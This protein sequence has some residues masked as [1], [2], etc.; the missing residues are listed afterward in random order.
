MNDVKSQTDKSSRL[1]TLTVENNA[2]IASMDVTVTA[3]ERKLYEIGFFDPMVNQD[4]EPIQQ[5]EQFY[6]S[7]VE[8]SINRL[9]VLRNRLDDI[10]KY[11]HELI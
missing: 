11:L 9:V 5:E 7:T 8:N 2:V 4:K 6:L 3:I 10:C 1:Y